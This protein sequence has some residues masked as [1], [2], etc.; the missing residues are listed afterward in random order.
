MK[1][2]REVFKNLSP[3]YFNNDLAK[4]KETIY[5][6]DDVKVT[7]FDIISDRISIELYD[8]D[9]NLYVFRVGIL[10]KEVIVDSIINGEFNRNQIV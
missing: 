9:G 2:W 6:M 3:F 5:N 10:S 8:K 4:Y 1:Y 7:R